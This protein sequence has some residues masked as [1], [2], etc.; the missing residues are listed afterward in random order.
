M[1]TLALWSVIDVTALIAGLAVYLFI[2]GRQLTKVAGA[3]EEA[4]DLV[5]EIKK[6]AEVI[7]SGL[8]QINQT[9]G[10]VAGALP[11]L[12][13]MAEGIVTGATYVPEAH[14]DSVNK[15]AMGVRRS[16]QMHGV[17]VHID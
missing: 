9:G 5:W 1:S 11:L 7:H 15:P 17:G 2:V 13:G 10:I 12:Y 8:T 3:L 6:D 14:V 4:A 16:R